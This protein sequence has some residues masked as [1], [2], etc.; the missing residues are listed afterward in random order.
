MHMDLK[1]FPLPWIPIAASYL[2]IRLLFSHAVF[3]WSC[4]PCVSGNSREIC[5]H[6]ISCPTKINGVSK[7]LNLL[8]FY[9][10]IWAT[11]LTILSVSTST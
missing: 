8:Q 1:L 5:R 7:V 2:C 6:I 10:H 11:F 4:F 9:Y 3:T